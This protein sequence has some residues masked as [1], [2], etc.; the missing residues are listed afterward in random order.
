M[1]TIEVQVLADKSVE[2]LTA[3]DCMEVETIEFSGR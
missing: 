2:T 1:Q 3:K